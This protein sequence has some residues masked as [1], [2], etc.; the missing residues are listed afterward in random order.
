MVVLVTLA[1]VNAI[2]TGWVTALDARQPSDLSRALGG[3]PRQVSAGLSAAQ[4]LKAL[5]GALLG[6]PRHPAVRDREQRGSG[7]GPPGVTRGPAGRNR[8]GPYRVQA[9]WD[10]M[11]D[12]PSARSSPLARLWPWPA[13]APRPRQ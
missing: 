10:E 8:G 12:V 2:V 4:L 13:A 7:V 11:R 6:V 9:A 1:A 5:P 3:S